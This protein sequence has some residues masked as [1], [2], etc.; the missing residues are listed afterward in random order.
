MTAGAIPLYEDLPELGQL[1][2]RHSWGHLPPEKGTLSFLGTQQ[3]I[4]AASLV[5]TGTVIPL[6]LPVN[7][8]DP[9]LFDRAPLKHE[10]VK[11]SRNDAEDIIHDFN[12]Q[13]SSQLDGLGHVRARE[14]GY[15]GGIT[16]LDE[17]RE[18]L[19]MHHWASNGIAGRGVLLDVAAYRAASG[20]SA[21]PFSGLGY[22]PE[23]LIE[24]AE[25]ADVQL[26]PGD[27]LLVR[28]GWAKA[29]LALDAKERA[30]IP[31]WDGLRADEQTAQFLWDH[32]ISLVGSDNP[33]VENA[34]GHPSIGSLHRRLLPSLGMPLMEL[35]D[36]E[37]LGLECK[38]QAKWDFLFV[39]V[40]LNLRGAVSSPANA[41]AML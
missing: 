19:G 23:L 15:Y 24:T 7:A 17:A 39:S 41:M 30:M 40:P 34:P 13:A 14:L 32:R 18:K 25:W 11:A 9:P 4:E 12:P 29:Y 3:V 8:F 38:A 10:V 35:L 36:L 26:R 33:A 20:H 5:T 1:G 21:D 2:T 6:N 37:N 28:T 22:T 31:G 27:I 16:E